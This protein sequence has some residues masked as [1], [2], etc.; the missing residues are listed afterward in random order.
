MKSSESSKSVQLRQALEAMES[1]FGAADAQR[2][3]GVDVQR[4]LQQNAAFKAQMLQRRA[5]EREAETAGV[6]EAAATGVQG[7]GGALPH[8]DA[9]QKSFGRH[10]V[11]A[12]QAFVGGQAKAASEAIGAEAYA[13]GNRIAFRESPTL[14]TAAH[15]AAHVVQQR[16][17]VSLSGGVGQVGDR[18]EQHAD[19]VADRVVQGKSAEDLLDAF[20]GGG[21]RA[22]VQ[23]MGRPET[24]AE[25]EFV[26]P[27]FLGK[28]SQ[29]TFNT[30]KRQLTSGKRLG[31]A[32]IAGAV[33][34]AAMSSPDDFIATQ[35]PGVIAG[36]GAPYSSEAEAL[37]QLAPIVRSRICDTI[38]LFLVEHD[39]ALS[40]EE[41]Q[42]WQ[43]V[44]ARFSP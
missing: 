2:A 26:M 16:V 43:A 30:V 34:L 25:L 24:S 38:N 19:A 7:S 6:L 22:G 29:K 18:Y 5:A 32:I 44:R 40:A 13:T 4:Q 35:A 8:L 10:D 28:A 41:Q 20:A 12:V 39:N 9:I 42:Y 37:T 14:H 27:P 21:T 15:E 23:R 36:G 33:I 31:P 3:N 17:G 11:S 1:R